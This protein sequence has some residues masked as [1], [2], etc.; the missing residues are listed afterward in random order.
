MKD[1]LKTIFG[2]VSVA[3]TSNKKTLDKIDF[4]KIFIHT[5]VVSASAA[6]VVLSEQFMK[7]DAGEWN[8]ILIP[9]VSATV[10]A[11]QKWLKGV[12]QKPE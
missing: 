8:V 5:L 4:Y 11:I 10:V 6:V 7:I 9:V 2:T 1:L 12:D 3:D